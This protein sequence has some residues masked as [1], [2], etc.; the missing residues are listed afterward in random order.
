MVNAP[1]FVAGGIV[2][3]DTVIEVG[4]DVQPLP[5]VSWITTEYV[6]AAKPVMV[7]VELNGAEFAPP[8]RE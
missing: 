6:A 7:V 5:P 4:A 8:L 1:Q 3:P 2:Q